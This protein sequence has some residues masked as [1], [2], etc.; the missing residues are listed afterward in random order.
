MGNINFED[1]YKVP[2]LS[3]DIIKLR[4]DLNIVLKKK[5]LI[6]QEFQI[7]VLYLLIKF[8]TMITQLK[9]TI[10][11][12]CIGLSLMKMEEK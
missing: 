12:V 2:E 8:Q 11:E 3:F 10:L 5:N 7:L 4:E 6:V 1:F 9:V